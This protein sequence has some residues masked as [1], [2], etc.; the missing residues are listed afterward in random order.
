MSKIYVASVA[1][2]FPESE[3]WTFGPYNSLEECFSQAV[4]HCILIG[5]DVVGTDQF[6]FT[7]EP[8]EFGGISLRYKTDGMLFK[9]IDGFNIS[10]ESLTTEIG[11]H[12]Q[13]LCENM[14]IRKILGLK[15]RLDEILDLCANSNIDRNKGIVKR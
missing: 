14:D 1:Q 2:K 15:T 13:R 11:T 5:K 12:K 7:F 3:H 8:M 9:K 10:V 6:E 4:E